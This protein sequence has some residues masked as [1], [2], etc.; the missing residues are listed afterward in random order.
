MLSEHITEINGI[1]A[2]R[3]RAVIEQADEAFWRSIGQGFPEVTA[4]NFGPDDLIAWESARNRAVCSWLQYNAPRHGP[5][6]HRHLTP[7]DM[8]RHITED[9][10]EDL[11]AIDTHVDPAPYLIQH[12]IPSTSNHGLD[13]LLVWHQKDHPEQPSPAPHA[14]PAGTRQATRLLI[15]VDTDQ[16][17]ANQVVIGHARQL[18]EAL[19]RD[20]SVAFCVTVVDAQDAELTGWIARHE[21]A[22]LTG[23]VAR[24]EQ[25]RLNAEDLALL[26]QGDTI[27]LPYAGGVGQATL[28]GEEDFTSEQLQDLAAGSEVV[29]STGRGALRVVTAGSTNAGSDPEFLTQIEVAPDGGSFRLHRTREDA[30]PTTEEVTASELQEGD[31]VVSSGPGTFLQHGPGTV[32]RKT[33]FSRGGRQVGWRVT[34]DQYA[35]V[36]WKDDKAVT[37]RKR[38]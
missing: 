5:D 38:T 29:I 8:A 6:K 7:A 4:G 3:I 21:H 16:P 10:G 24:H 30:A 14:S 12:G 11:A 13:V 35:P 34:F 26:R 19:D 17:F 32:R 22:E 27:E 20:G 2:G 1:P 31:Q 15:V 36:T 33:P 23:W 18:A 37:I 9:H 25:V 28:S